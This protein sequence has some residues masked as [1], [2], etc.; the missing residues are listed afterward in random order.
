MVNDATRMKFSKALK[1]KDGVVSAIQ[2]GITNGGDQRHIEHS[3]T[4][5]HDTKEELIKW[6]NKLY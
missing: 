6:F 5:K 3:M 1:P 4:E 2:P